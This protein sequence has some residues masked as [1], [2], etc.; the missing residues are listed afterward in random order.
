MENGPLNFTKKKIKDLVIK[1]LLWTVLLVLT[2]QTVQRWVADVCLIPSNSMEN[3]ILAGDRILV[4]KSGSNAIR[5]NDVMIFNHPDGS[6]VQLIKRCIGLPGDTV[7]LHDGVVYINGRTV[8]VPPTVKM[9][10]ED[11]P[12]DFPLQSLGWTINN[13]GPVVTPAKGLSV[14]LDSVN[15]NL[16]R[17]IIGRETEGQ[18]PAEC[19]TFRTDCYFVLGDNRNHSIDSRYWGF[20]PGYAII[21]KATF[22]YF[23]RDPNQKTIRWN[24]IGKVLS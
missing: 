18:M 20:V 6:G 22:V 7:T 9:S 4:C 12:V 11:Y 3:T 15:T 21:G 14:P 16:Y 23:S 24:R 13:Y 5:R 17:H 19:H 1:T 2:V 10:P 8:A